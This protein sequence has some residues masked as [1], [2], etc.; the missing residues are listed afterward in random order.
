MA[1]VYAKD[2]GNKLSNPNIKNIIT[3]NSID[4]GLPPLIIC[5]EEGSKNVCKHVSAIGITLLCILIKL[6]AMGDC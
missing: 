6:R 3:I 1:K 2:I 4:L 5:S